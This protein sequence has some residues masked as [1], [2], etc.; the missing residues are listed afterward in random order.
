MTHVLIIAMFVAV[1]MRDARDLP[2]QPGWGAA[3]LVGACLAAL[4]V[5][6]AITAAVAARALDATG[7]PAAVAILDRAGTGLRLAAGAVVVSAI[8]FL[9]FLDSIRL[10][11]GDLVLFDELAAMLPVLAF[12]LLSWWISYPFERRLREAMLLRHLYDGT[13]LHPLPSRAE[14]VVS[15]FRHQALLGL[16]PLSLITGWQ[17]GLPALAARLTFDQA[18][19]WTAAEPY[20]LWGGVLAAI[21]LTPAIIRYA[22]DTTPI[23][24]GSVRDIV[25][26]VCAR[27]RVRIRGPLLWRT[28]NAMLNG[29]VIGVVYPFRYM[30]FTD[31]LL[32][33]LP[34]A[35]LEGV[36]AHEVAHVRLRHPLW[37]LLFV[38]ASAIAL[39]WGITALSLVLPLPQW[40][41]ESSGPFAALSLVLIL[42]AFGW[43]SRRFEWQADAFAVRH[44][45]GVSL[46]ADQSHTAISRPAVDA[47]IDALG[48][49]ADLNGVPR[50]RGDF[51]HGSIARRQALLA[52]LEGADPARL[53]ID[54]TVKAIKISTAAVLALGLL[55]AF[56]P[57]TGAAP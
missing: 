15:A 44:L 35:P 41:Q 29:A 2:P 56:L 36:V 54:R 34:A 16:L 38:L 45:S 48:L 4:A 49:V 25:A 55:L 46:P 30:L 22:W 5:V 8:L 37:L 10:A 42:G 21:I 33:S 18:P 40:F 50:S 47:M 20:L 39:G 53:P 12:L 11:M 28:H 9:N 31:A 6:H 51:R 24:P 17:E 57:T 14:F 7:N 23:G 3:W 43:A 32:E 26:R 27:H 1:H 13:P 52:G 19:L